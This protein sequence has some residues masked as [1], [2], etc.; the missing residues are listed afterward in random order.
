MATPDSVKYSSSPVE[1]TS[2]DS[3]LTIFRS[4]LN[5][6]NPTNN[7]FIRINLPV[8]DKSWIDWSDSV[9]SMKLT[10]MSYA[11][12]G[13][14]GPAHAAAR[15]QLS[16]LIKSVSVINS[17]GQQIEYINNYNLIVNIMDDYTVGESHKAGVDQLLGGG[18]P[19]GKPEEAVTIAGAAGNAGTA[20]GGEKVLVDSLMTG[21]TSGQ[22]LIPIGYCIG[23]S[24]S[25]VIELEDPATCLALFNTTVTNLV[26][27]YKVEN[28]QIRAK[29][30]SF[31]S[32]FNQVFEENLME[33][34]PEGINYITET[35]LHNQGTL[36]SGTSGQQNIQFSTNPRSAKYILAAMRLEADIT[37][38]QKYSIGLR[39]SAAIDQYSWEISGKIYP[40]QPIEVKDDNVSESFANVLDC[41][42][43]IGNINHNTLLSAKAGD[44]NLYYAANQ[45]T[46]Q[47]FVSGLVLEDFNSATNGSTYSGANLSTVGTMSFRP[48]LNANLSGAYRVDFF[49]SCDMSLH[50]TSDGRI[51]TVK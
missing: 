48:R 1:S 23:Q 28:V 27:A 32:A 10:N 15:T 26:A 21:F 13:S 14:D 42:G 33:A 2:A 34:G 45:A 7:K 49:T 8:A 39:S 22:F 6:Y 41:L 16:N 12:S 11:T 30:I 31:N 46:S 35:F 36:T 51:Y 29:Q 18:S 25:L 5:E 44:S 9:L 50:I 38:K 3:E 19:N 43:Q 4:E 20:N 17:Q 37:N 40:T 24:M 47:K